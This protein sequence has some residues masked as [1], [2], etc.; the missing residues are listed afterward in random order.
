VLCCA[1][2]CIAS[3]SLSV[4]HCWAAQ[5]GSATKELADL[6][7]RV[8]QLP[9]LEKRLADAERENADVQR[10]YKEEQV[11]RKRYWNMMEDMK[12]KIRVYARCRPMSSSETER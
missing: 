7:D 6:R 1:A 12:G 9:Q 10:L 5:L 2:L 8:A 4:F 3:T 11:L